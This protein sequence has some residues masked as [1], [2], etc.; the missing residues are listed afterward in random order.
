MTNEVEFVGYSARIVTA[1]DRQQCAVLPIRVGEI[2]S[3][4]PEPNFYVLADDAGGEIASR[5]DVYIPN[6]DYDFRRSAIIWQQWIVIG[7]GCRAI[8]V[9]LC[10]QTFQ[11]MTV[12]DKQVC[13]VDYFSAFIIET[14]YLIACFGTG[15]VRI[16]P[17]GAASWKNHKLGIDGVIVGQIE[18]EVI[19]GDGEWDPPGG[20]RPF[21]VSLKTGRAIKTSG[22]MKRWGQRVR[23]WFR[24]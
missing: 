1:L 24:P 18:G 5:V 22:W 2:P 13:G 20:W 10:D 9:S 15:L 19:H 12:S 17:N 8:L 7:F 23:N 6:G 14:H 11:E 16:E 21:Q 4:L 3:H